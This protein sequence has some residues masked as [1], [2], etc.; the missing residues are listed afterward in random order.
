M[1]GQAMVNHRQYPRIAQQHF[2]HT[3]RSRVAV[4][5]GQHIGVQQ[6]AQGR[7]GQGEILDQADGA[8]V[9]IT[10]ILAAL[11]RGVA[12]FQARLAEQ[13]IQGD[14]E[15]VAD[16]EIFTFLTQVHRPQAH[17][18][19]RAAQRFEDLRHGI[20]RRQLTTAVLAT[21]AAIAR[22][23]LVPRAAQLADNGG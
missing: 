12:Q 13:G 16:V 6:A 18:K 21:H 10:V 9:D 15:G 17:R 3:A 20:A 5:G 11:A 23:P 4:V 1:V 19:Q 14:V 22:S 8:G 2:I 7:Q